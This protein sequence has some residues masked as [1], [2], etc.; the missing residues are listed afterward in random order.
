MLLLLTQSPLT[1]WF[2]LPKLAKFAPGRLSADSVRLGLDGKLRVNSIAIRMPG[3][4]TP[5][6]TFFEAVQLKI[7]IDWLS[8]AGNSPRVSSLVLVEP[9]VRITQSTDDAT[10]NLARLNVPSMGGAA[11]GGAGGPTQIPRVRV[12]RGIIEI[13]EHG[14][15]GYTKLR[16]V[17]VSG[18]LEPEI[19]KEGTYALRLVETRSDGNEGVRV[20][21]SIGT[22]QGEVIATRLRLEDWPPD[23]VPA[24]I[25]EA[26]RRLG[27]QGEITRATLRYAA[28]QPLSAAL[29]LDGVGVTLPIT[30]DEADQTAERAAA[31]ARG[32]RPAPI[33]VQERSGDQML[34][35]ENVSGQVSLNGRQVEANVTGMLEDLPYR[36]RLRFEDTSADAAFVCELNSEGFEVRAHPEILRFAPTVA[37]ERVAQFCN[38]T[39]IVDAWIRVSRGAPTPAGPGAISVRGSLRLRDTVAAFDKFPYQFSDMEGTILFDEN[40]IEFRDIRGRSAS[41][42]TV[43]ARGIVAPPTST[44]EVNVEVTV[45]GAPIDEALLT[46]M[47]PQRRK[48]LDTLMSKPAFDQLVAAGLVARAGSPAEAAASLPTPAGVT[49]LFAVGGTADIKVNVHRELGEVSRWR[50][51]VEV[52]LPAAGILPEQFRYP[53]IGTDVR[54]VVEKGLA[55][56]TEGT[57]RGL[58]GG[59]A[60]LKAGVK[61]AKPGEVGVQAMP[62]VDARATGMPIDELLLNAV[63]DVALTGLSG[64][65]RSVREMLDALGLSGTIACD[66]RVFDAGD[67]TSGYQLN[68]RPELARAAPTLGNEPVGIRL[69]DLD[70]RIDIDRS[71]IDVDLRA[72]LTSDVSNG[73]PDASL[74]LKMHSDFT[75][76]VTGQ[77]PGTS[78]VAKLERAPADAAYDKVA[79]LFSAETS[80]RLGKTLAQL[81]PSGRA[82]ATITFKTGAAGSEQSSVF[83]NLN[84]LEFNL[85]QGRLRVA[86]STGSARVEQASQTIVTFRNLGLR[87]V[88]DAGSVG[89]ITLDGTAVGGDSWRIGDDALRIT[90]TDLEIGSTTLR[91]ELAARLGERA[92]NFQ[93]DFSPAGRVDAQIV[94]QQEPDAIG[95]RGSVTPRSLAFT[96]NATRVEFGQAQGIIEFDR[97]GGTIRDLRLTAPAWSLSAN[98][99]WAFQ[100]GASDLSR[101]EATYAL[102][103]TSFPPNL[104]AALPEVLQDVLNDID[105]SDVSGLEVEGGTLSVSRP[106]GSESG[107]FGVKTSGRLKVTDAAFNVG[108]QIT[109]CNGSM[110]FDVDR[111]AEG[112]TQFSLD[113]DLRSL[114]VAGVRVSD[115]VVE[116]RSGDAPGQVLVPRISADCHAGRLV[117]E[118]ML[119]PGPA[120]SG[121]DDP[122]LNYSARLQLSNVR[123]GPV[124]ADLRDR[125][126]EPAEPESASRDPEERGFLSAELTLA[127]TVGDLQSRRGRGMAEI[128]GGKVISMPLVLAL[129]RAS[130]LQLPVGEK[131]RLGRSTFFIEGPV[132]AFEDMSFFAENVEILGYGTLTWPETAL[133]MRFNSRS[134]NRVPIISGLVEG[135]RDQFVSTVVDGTLDD[136]KV[137]VSGLGGTRRL[138]DRLFGS[139]SEQE[140]RMEDIRRRAEVERSREFEGR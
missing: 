137:G 70:G 139:E 104:K 35:L 55:Q 1:T 90:A 75:R 65:A 11:A 56:V 88:E 85:G 81:K 77:Q 58:R 96:R 107:A 62:D 53:I 48:V 13:G 111:R 78:V 112:A 114:R 10:L 36:V 79:A 16:E 106:G 69:E 4:P 45:T 127:G 52:T 71:M 19:G 76:P 57:F 34:R 105:F 43:R 132:V 66:A 41:G 117:G 50:D 110:A 39:G 94:L 38:P 97:H 86:D 9:R 67:G 30:G 102:S 135:I 29:D 74:Q 134:L 47:G 26:L 63:P 6:S 22:R 28:G 49:P 2:V 138:I 72:A 120:S 68:I 44:S 133:E 20:Q 21:G 42:A 15:N 123:F 59:S 23:S 108:L 129:V 60:V 125:P 140:R 99:V 24:P 98:G 113:G 83:E 93:R 92:I 121:N 3:D 82:D 54:I 25:R 95:V 136:P 64:Q 100:P 87:L 126:G 61:L 17:R 14:S 124:L 12:E 33:N 18:E 84:G 91:A 27:L 7:G 103:S 8:L 118:A 37:K 89:S 31:Q 51:R 131:I 122:P 73:A 109:E 40:A 116:V 32:E 101:L 115:A 46:A 128:G 80:A 5:E 130:N 119:T